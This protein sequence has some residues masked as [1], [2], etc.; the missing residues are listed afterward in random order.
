MPLSFTDKLRLQG[1]ASTL[2]KQLKS[3]SLGF[4]EKLTK[5]AEW[6]AII[7]QLKGSPT[8]AQPP[9]PA[10]VSEAE[11]APAPLE[12]EE[13]TDEEAAQVAGRSLVGFRLAGV[14]HPKWALKFENQ[15][16]SR[17]ADLVVSN[18]QLGVAILW[19]PSSGTDQKAMLIGWPRYL[20]GTNQEGTGSTLPAS[21]AWDGVKSPFP[22][23]LRKKVRYMVGQAEREVARALESGIASFTVT[24]K[25]P[26]F[27]VRLIDEKGISGNGDT[28]S[29]AAAQY[30]VTVRGKD[31]LQNI[32]QAG[33]ARVMNLAMNA[34]LY[35]VESGNEDKSTLPTLAEWDA[36]VAA[37]PLDAIDDVDA[38]LLDDTRVKLAAALGDESTQEQAQEPAGDDSPAPEGD[39]SQKKGG[40]IVERYI[41][42]EFKDAPYSEFRAAV[43]DVEKAGATFEQI[44]GGAIEWVE[45][46]PELIQKAA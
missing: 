25:N 2:N 34:L 3:G 35:G 28:V 11:P 27:S 16:S 42:G 30:T 12:D 24:L 38:K 14:N 29:N 5:Q 21:A 43:L 26:P 4:M 46:N 22:P 19:R 44:Q 32:A 6:K 20:K 9:A 8:P 33:Q 37:I 10:A 13:G 45:A 41:T 15:N 1:E 7:D 36:L 18:D 17:S 23:S 39:G 40:G 31:G